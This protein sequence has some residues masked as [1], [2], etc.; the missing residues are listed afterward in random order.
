MSDTPS[1][2]QIGLCKNPKDSCTQEEK[3][4]IMIKWL[5]RSSE[6]DNATYFNATGFSGCDLT[7]YEFDRTTREQ[8]PQYVPRM[9][10]NINDYTRDDFHAM[11]AEELKEKYNGERPDCV[12][13]G[14]KGESVAKFIEDNRKDFLNQHCKRIFTLEP[15]I[16]GILSHYTQFTTK[17]ETQEDGSSKSVYL[18]H[19]FNSVEACRSL[20]ES[21]EAISTKPKQ[22]QDAPVIPLGI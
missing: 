6:A 20:I 2:T 11:F 15:G 1:V 18:P 13:Y 8:V 9:I 4:L 17:N 22:T 7:T 19:G 5:Q 12:V 3:N 10:T 21:N 14:K 16:E